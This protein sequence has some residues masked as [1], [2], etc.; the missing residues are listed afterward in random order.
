MLAELR[1]ARGLSQEELGKSIGKNQD[2][3]YHREKGELRIK[4]A[5]RL[6]L[7]KA[8]GV[9]EVALL[10]SESGSQL[11]NMGALIPGPTGKVKVYGAVSAGDGNTSTFDPAEVDVPMELCRPDFGALVIEGDSMMDFLHPADVAIFKDWKTEKL[12]HIVAAELPDGTWVTKHMVFEDGTFK[13]R[14]LNGKYPDIQPP[15]RIAGFLVGLVRDDG[16]ER[17]IRLNPFG[18]KI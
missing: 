1:K 6:R 17:L 10:A 9:P 18:L 13:L 2:W 11:P 12:G 16:P 7:A 3:V 15:F 8:L 14:S 5:D 4:P